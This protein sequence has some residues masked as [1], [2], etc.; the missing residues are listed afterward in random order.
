[1]RCL[2]DFGLVESDVL[3]ALTDNCGKEAGAASLM[4]TGHPADTCRN[5][6]LALCVGYSIGSKLA[7]RGPRVARNNT[8]GAKLLSRKRKMVA[9]FHQSAKATA[10]LKELQIAELLKTSPRFPFDRPAGSLKKP[11]GLPAAVSTSAAPSSAP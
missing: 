5:H 7:K 8:A 10:I 6:T 4:N 1:M 11:R 2:T 3:V 9:H